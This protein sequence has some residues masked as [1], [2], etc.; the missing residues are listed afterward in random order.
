VGRALRTASAVSRL[1]HVDYHVGVVRRSAVIGLLVLSGALFAATC[2]G[3]DG[4]KGIGEPCTRDGECLHD[5]RCQG[6]VCRE[7]S[8]DAGVTDASSSDAG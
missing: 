2:G 7:P 4:Q 5:L 8:T 6:G 3:D 1:A